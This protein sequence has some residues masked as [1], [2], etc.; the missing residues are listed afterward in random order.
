M[1]TATPLITVDLVT[2]LEH[3]VKPQVEFSAL[4]H[5][6]EHYLF[7]HRFEGKRELIHSLALAMHHVEETWRNL[8][9][10]PEPDVASKPSEHVDSRDQS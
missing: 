3:G 8:A 4:D 7:V 5:D 1:N 10:A 9:T 6:L 2:E